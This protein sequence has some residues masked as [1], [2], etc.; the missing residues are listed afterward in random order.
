MG[1]GGEVAVSRDAQ[2]RAHRLGACKE[3]QAMAG[4]VPPP[5]VACPL[6]SR[7][8]FLTVGSPQAPLAS[9][10]GMK[11]LHAINISICASVQPIL[12][13]TTHMF[14]WA[15]EGVLDGLRPF[16]ALIALAA[17]ARQLRGSWVAAVG[18]E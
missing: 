13:H 12:C 3:G 2:E 10:K 7:E 15:E 11:M 9:L 1:R 5:H 8:G 18:G 14:I 17:A 6:S 4:L 16:G